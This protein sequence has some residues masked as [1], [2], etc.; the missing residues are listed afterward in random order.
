MPRLS[1]GRCGVQRFGNGFRRKVTGLTTRSYPLVEVHF[2]LWAVLT[3]PIGF[4]GLFFLLPGLMLVEGI[5]LQ[6]I[7]GTLLAYVWHLTQYRRAAWL[8]GLL[9]HSALLIG[10]FYYVPIWPDLLAVPLA[11]ANLYS[12]LVLA[13]HRRLWSGG[14]QRELRPA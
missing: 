5:V 10:A 14:P 13:V 7:A 3:V 11:L 8:F 6:A 2:A 9:L 1:C 4:A 12:L